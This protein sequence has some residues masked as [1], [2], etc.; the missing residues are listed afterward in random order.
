V[1]HIVAA[2][3]ITEHHSDLLREASEARRANL[4]Q[5]ARRSPWS[6]FSAKLAGLLGPSTGTARRERPAS[7]STGTH[8]AAA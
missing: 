6:A 2:I 5:G 4:L 1:N 8:P 3:L 7:T